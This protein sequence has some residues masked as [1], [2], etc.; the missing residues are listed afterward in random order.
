MPRYPYPC[1]ECTKRFLGCHSTCAEYI[2][3]K[4]IQEEKNNKIREQKFMESISFSTAPKSRR[5]A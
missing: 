1:K 5:R 3:A 2:E 4:S